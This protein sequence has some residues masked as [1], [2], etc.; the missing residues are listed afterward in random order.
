MNFDRKFQK[1]QELRQT[2]EKKYK[3]LVDLERLS[4]ATNMRTTPPSHFYP[5]DLVFYK[6]HQAPREGR[7]HQLLD[8]PRRQ[9]ARWYGPGILGLETKV[10]YNGSIR[11]PHRFAW[12]ISQGR[13]KRVHMDQLRHSS[14]T[15]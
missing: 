4:K 8:V 14:V 1:Q 15:R 2:A 13:L 7:S 5:G 3:E 11:Q 10:T 12:V 9:V 6:R